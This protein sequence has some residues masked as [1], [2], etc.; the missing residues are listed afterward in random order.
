M[1]EILIVK[2][3][4][5]IVCKKHINKSNKTHIVSPNLFEK[6]KKIFSDINKKENEE[7]I[8]DF[9]TLSYQKNIGEI[10]TIKNYVGLIQIDNNFQIEVLPKITF[11]EDNTKEDNIICRKVLLDMLKALKIFSY[12]Q[13]SNSFVN[14]A[15]MPIY[16][17]FIRIFIEEL[18]ELTK[19]G[20]K[21]SYITIEENLPFYKGKLLINQ[22]IN[23]N[24]IHKERF[25][26]EYDSFLADIPE[27]KII[28]TTLQK[29]LKKTTNSYTSK[30]INQLLILFD[31]VSLST[32]YT[33]DFS[34]I[35]ITRINKTY[36]NIL[37]WAKIFLFEQ[38]FTSFSGKN[39]FIS[40]LFPMEKLYESYVTQKI[41]HAFYKDNWQVAIQ[42]SLYHLITEPKKQFALRPDIVLRKNN[43]CII[44]DTKWKLLSNNMPNHG[45]N[46]SDMYQMYAYSKKYNTPYVWLLYPKVP[47]FEKNEIIYYKSEDNTIIHIFFIDLINITTSIHI[48]KNK[49]IE[50]LSTEYFS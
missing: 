1:K 21:F 6:I 18:T 5:N 12:K 32:N 15:S 16:E 29:L 10:I 25:F 23:K 48:L 42:D 17:V 27:N 31:N 40:L 47:C 11:T 7:N 3:F 36:K 2:E 19:K 28:K 8:L 30:K 22:H 39:N 33:K 46:Q 34:S 43:Y 4:D 41:Q 44:L 45:I 26:V 20:I 35:T 9:L 37:A 50:S 38:S 14:I 13:L 49:I 24:L